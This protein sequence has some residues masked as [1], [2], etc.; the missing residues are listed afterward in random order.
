MEARESNNMENDRVHNLNEARRSREATVNPDASVTSTQQN[1][2]EVTRDLYDDFAALMTKEREL[3]RTEMNEKYESAKSGFMSSAVG[4]VFFTLSLMVLTATAVIA[5]AYIMDLWLAALI[6]GIACLAIGG[7]LFSVG[8]KKLEPNSLKP[9]RSIS[10]FNNFGRRMKER[11][12][13]IR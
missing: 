12:Y 13:D 3:I 4:I 5:L 11:Y 9:N 10:T 8:K 1:W 7:I 6:V 2:R